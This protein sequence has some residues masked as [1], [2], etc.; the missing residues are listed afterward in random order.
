M[1]KRTSNASMKADLYLM[2]C[3]F[4]AAVIAVGMMLTGAHYTLLNT[5]Y[6]GITVFLLLMT[7]FFGLTVGI[8]VNMVFIF[9]Q[10]LVMIYLK[11]TG[12]QVALVMAMWLIAPSALNLAF[13]AMT[14]QLREM[15]AENAR[16]SE[17][18]VEH[19]AFDQSTNLRTTVAFLEDAGVFIETSRRFKI[20]VSVVMIR[21]RYFHDLRTMLGEQRIQE[22]V[23]LVSQTVQA[24]TRDNDI[25][26]WLNDEDPTWGVLVYAD[27][28]GANIA[29]DRIKRRFE[30]SLQATAALASVD[31][32]LKI[33]VHTWQ[34]DAPE[35]ANA[36]MASGIKELEY[37]V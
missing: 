2:S 12:G 36:F 31:L 18:M 24:A 23:S 29:A 33:G 27:A 16:L 4:L 8:G 22:L 32:T 19:G 25:T 37:D 35:D 10:A 11:L 15:Q 3:V 17:Q 30:E 9:A 20:P 14:M 7:Y 21:I 26:Y 5:A 28:A 34:A 1:H 6:L 13:Y